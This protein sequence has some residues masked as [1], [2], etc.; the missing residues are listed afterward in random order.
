M[1]DFVLDLLGHLVG[2]AQRGVGVTVDVHHRPELAAHPARPHVMHCEHAL[3]APCGLGNLVD[4]MRIDGVQHP[5]EELADGAGQHVNDRQSDQDSGDGVGQAQPEPG[6]PDAG[7]GACR[8][9]GI[10]A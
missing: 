8:N 9:Q 2:L 7:E 3:D 1:A 6:Q 4:Q 10:D 5:V